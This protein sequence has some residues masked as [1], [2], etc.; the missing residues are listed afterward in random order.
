MDAPSN[1][2]KD[3]QEFD[4]WWNEGHPNPISS[5]DRSE[6]GEGSEGHEEEAAVSSS[7]AQGGDVSGHAAYVATNVHFNISRDSHTRTWVAKPARLTPQ[8]KDLTFKVSECPPAKRQR[9]ESVIGGVSHEPAGGEVPATSQMPEF[10]GES[11]TIL[12]PPL[13]SQQVHFAPSLSSH[14]FVSA[15]ALLA[16]PVISSSPPPSASG[17]SYLVGFT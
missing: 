1:Q 16:T 9:T 12:E 17:P 13:T 15:P 8:Q 5:V 11:R 3:D 2:L 10:A 7:S 14:S 6:E 4:R